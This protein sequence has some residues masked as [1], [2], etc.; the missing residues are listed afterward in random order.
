ML[1]KPEL[2]TIDEAYG[3]WDCIQRNLQNESELARDVGFNQKNCLDVYLSSYPRD[4]NGQFIDRRIAALS[5]EIDAFMLQERFLVA[6]A[7]RHIQPL[8]DYVSFTSLVPGNP[9]DVATYQVLAPD[10]PIISNVLGDG[11]CYYRAALFNIL[12]EAATCSDRAKRE[13]IFNK[14]EA[15]F[16]T[17]QAHHAADQKISNAC[18]LVLETLRAG[19][20]SW[21][22]EQDIRQAFNQLSP[23]MQAKQTS[24]IEQRL[25]VANEKHRHYQTLETYAQRSWNVDRDDIVTHATIRAQTAIIRKIENILADLPDQVDTRDYRTFLNNELSDARKELDRQMQKNLPKPPGKDFENIIAAQTAFMIASTEERFL[26]DYHTIQFRREAYSFDNALM[27]ATRCA[28]A[29]TYLT[30]QDTEFHGMKLIDADRESDAYQEYALLCLT[31]GQEPNIGDYVRNRIMSREINAEGPLVYLGLLPALFGFESQ[32][33]RLTANQP[34]NAMQSIPVPDSFGTICYHYRGQHYNAF[35]SRAATLASYPSLSE[36]ITALPRLDNKIPGWNSPIESNRGARAHHAVKPVSRSES[37]AVESK[38]SSIQRRLHAEIDQ[39]TAESK[40]SGKAGGV[41]RVYKEQYQQ[42][43]A[44]EEQ[45]SQAVKRATR[46]YLSKCTE[47][48]FETPFNRF[49]KE[50]RLS[51]K[52]FKKE[53]RIEAYVHGTEQLTRLIEQTHKKMQSGDVSA[54]EQRK[55]E[56]LCLLRDQIVIEKLMYSHLKIDILHTRNTS[57]MQDQIDLFKADIADHMSEYDLPTKQALYQYIDEQLMTLI[58]E[59]TEY[60]GRIVPETDTA[61]KAERIV[62]LLEMFQELSDYCQMQEQY[63]LHTMQQRK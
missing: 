13:A 48:E 27:V 54:I 7:I 3:L 5:Q 17:T 62:D 14:I 26:V 53:Q 40:S 11:D 19:R 63:H 45:I 18:I 34:P 42:V 30:H 61:H 9:S 46:N 25:A 59:M 41:S 4:M 60:A 28:A 57:Q 35:L 16:L 2:H 24:L 51:I 8:A 38:A 10:Y 44:V 50:I 52:S 55:F 47:K 49:A 22:S 12:V 36:A 39:S 21:H 33:V 32:I 58:A 31:E 56:R 1:N 20:A 29:D 23:A 15:V 43:T 6:D 37:K